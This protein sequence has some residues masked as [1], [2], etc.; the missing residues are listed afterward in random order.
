MR[1]H[2]PGDTRYS[3][4]AHAEAQVRSSAAAATKQGSICLVSSKCAQ[5][6]RHHLMLSPLL[7]E[8]VGSSLLVRMTQLARSLDCK[9]ADRNIIAALVGG[10]HAESP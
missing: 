8:R 5:I 7:V 10:V 9:Q 4:A 1:F 6:V 3:S 2:A